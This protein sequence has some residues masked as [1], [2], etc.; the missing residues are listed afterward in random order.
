MGIDDI[1]PEAAR[2]TTCERFIPS[3]GQY[4]VDILLRKADIGLKM[5][6]LAQCMS[7]LRVVGPTTSQLIAFPTP[8]GIYDVS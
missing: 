7:Y 5:G 4:L 8:L 1:E 6:R 2:D 3:S